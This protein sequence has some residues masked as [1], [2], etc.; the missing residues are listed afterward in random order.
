M[1][2]A[3]AFG[4]IAT[5]FS[6]VLGGPFAV[7]QA[8]WPGSP[9]RDNAGRITAPATP[10]LKTCQ[11]QVCQ[12]TEQMRADAD[13]LQTDMRV[14]VLAASLDGELD[15]SA[16]VVIEAGPH[17]GRWDLQTVTLDSAGIG[18]TCRGRRGTA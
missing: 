7:A 15:T 18:W 4:Q 5:G 9:Q 8:V 1:N 14:I 10:I 13:F 3:A 6:G 17:A 12:P 11:A 2:L 16:D